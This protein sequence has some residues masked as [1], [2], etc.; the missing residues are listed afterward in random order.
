MTTWMPMYWGDYLKKTGHLTTEEHGAYLLL[1]CHLWTTGKPIPDDDRRLSA[2]TKSSMKKWKIM[3]PI[4]SEFFEILEGV[5]QHVRVN[6]EIAKSLEL[7]EKRALAGAEGGKKRQANAIAIG[8]ANAQAKG[9]AKSNQSQSQ[10]HSIDNS[11]EL[12]PPLFS[13]LTESE[14][15]DKSETLEGEFERFWKAYPRREDRK[16]AFK[17]FKAARK[18]AGIDA[19]CAAAED[20]ARECSAKGTGKDYMKHGSTWLN[21]ECWLNHVG[22]N[23]EPSE[24]DKH[25]DTLKKRAELLEKG[26]FVSTISRQDVEECRK[27][28]LI[29][30]A[31]YHTALGRV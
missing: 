17:A 13:D 5:W 8:I 23:E 18:K 19:I 29:S 7:K 31:A 3:R 16:A 14:T 11:N 22:K 12:S 24:H 25:L 10:S 4:L 28:G 1:I 30:E 15:V 20:Y 2:V 27:L 6:E 26:M 21:G 9:V